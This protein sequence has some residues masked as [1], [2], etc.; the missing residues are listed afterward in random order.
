MGVSRFAGCRAG[1]RLSLGFSLSK[2]RLEAVLFELGSKST[3]LAILV[4]KPFTVSGVARAFLSVSAP[5]N[6]G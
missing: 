3:D 2:V 5:G 1:L 4:G 6:G